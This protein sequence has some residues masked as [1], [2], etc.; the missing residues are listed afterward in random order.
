MTRTPTMTFDPIAEFETWLRA[1]VPPSPDPRF[2]VRRAVPAEFEAAYDLVDRVF[3]VRRPRTL[4]DW[5]YRRN[6][7][8]LARTWL[9]V[10]RASGRLVSVATWWPWPMV[11]RGAPMR[12]ALGG[13]LAVLP[14]WQRQGVTGAR[15]L[16]TEA[17]PYSRTLVRLSWPNDR[18]RSA[19]MKYGLSGL[20]DPM[21]HAVL[22]LNVRPSLQRRGPRWLAAAS[23]AVAETL[24]AAPS[25]L[26]LRGHSA[27]VVD[28][29]GRF[30]SAF[31]GL[32]SRS[33]GDVSFWCPH[34][35]A[36][37]NWRYLDHPI[38]RYVA[39]AAAGNTGPEGYGVLRLD[40]ERAVLMELVAPAS[41]PRIVRALLARALA[42]AREA[43][44]ARLEC[45]AP[46]RWPHWRLL[47]N[48]GF[49]RRRSDIRPWV[50]G[51]REP[52][53][54]RIEN[55]QLSGGDIDEL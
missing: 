16:V 45:I 27:V 2:S 24:L 44:C 23:R 26:A 18:S 7:F 51:P 48:A 6:P 41:P 39:F 10:E 43:G 34:D 22:V 52:G 15:R 9:V 29:V 50:L 8:G 4:Y 21:T 11:Q 30:D 25:R 38:R 31:D 55:W 54:D 49:M 36:F 35:A 3:Q 14:E 40:G 5:W 13:D 37:L 19:R 53:I 46:P 20:I 12:G 1:P 33:L 28:D 47:R 17:D 32:G 42:I